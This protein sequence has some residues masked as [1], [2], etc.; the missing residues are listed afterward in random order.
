MAHFVLLKK[1]KRTGNMIFLLS[2]S[3]H[4]PY[5]ATLWVFKHNRIDNTSKQK[6]NHFLSSKAKYIILNI[7]DAFEKEQTPVSGSFVDRTAEVT[8]VSRSTVDRVPLEKKETGILLSPKKTGAWTVQ[9][10]RWVRPGCR[11]T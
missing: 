7:S 9:I 5:R 4:V 1:N 8:D 11:K 2:C 10:D 3:F 6:S